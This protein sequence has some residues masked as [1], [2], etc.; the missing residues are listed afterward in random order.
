MYENLDTL[1]P[2]E[3]ATVWCDEYARTTG[4]NATVVREDGDWLYIQTPS[5][6]GQPW[7][8]G[9]LTLAIQTLRARPDFGTSIY[10]TPCMME[11][12]TSSR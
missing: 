3:L 6:E 7:Q 1:T 10:S 5:H 4:Y 11:C 2:H 8:R 9:H 12:E